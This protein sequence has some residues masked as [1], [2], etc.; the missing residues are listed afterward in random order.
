M[1]ADN[2]SGKQVRDPVADSASSEA[3]AR[4]LGLNFLECIEIEAG[5]DRVVIGDG[6][7]G[8]DSDLFPFLCVFRVD[9]VFK[10]MGLVMP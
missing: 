4:D 9:D 3:S 8:G 2:E 5:Y 10:F 1:H 6:I 7:A